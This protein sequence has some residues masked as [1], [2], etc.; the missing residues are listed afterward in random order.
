MMHSSTYKEHIWCNTYFAYYNFR[1][2]F[3][4]SFCIDGLHNSMWKKSSINL[5]FWGIF[6]AL[7]PLFK[8]RGVVLFAINNRKR[9]INPWCCGKQ[10]FLLQHSRFLF[11]IFYKILL[12]LWPNKVN[13]LQIMCMKLIF[14]LIQQ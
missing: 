1:R 7:C 8:G 6:D 3:T 12:K 11:Y 10:V 9:R 2:K 14:P 13:F 4:N 5:H